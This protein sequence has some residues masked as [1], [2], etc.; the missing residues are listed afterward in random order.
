MSVK[1]NNL[2]IENVKRVKAVQL[3]PTKDGLTIIGGKNNQGKTSVLDAIAWALGGEKFKPSQAERA[4]SI[5]PP[6]LRITLSN[7][8]IVER[9][10]KN[11][12]LKVTDPS[13]QK[14]G[15]KLLDAFVEKLAL[16]LPKFMEASNKEKANILLQV[17]GV[18]DQLGVI[19]TKEKELYQERTAIGRIADQKKKY[20]DEQPYYPDVP[21]EPVSAA[22][23][24][25]EQQDI[26]ARNGE[27]H[28]KRELANELERRVERIE[29]ELSETYGKAAEIE[30][31]L[32]LLKEEYNKAVED[33]EIAFKT[34]SELEDESTAK[35]EESIANIDEINR[36]VRANLDKEKAQA[37]ADMYCR[38][39]DEL[40]A[41]LNETRKEKLDLLRS[42]DLPLSGL[43]VVEG[44]LV[45]QGQRWDNMSGSEQLRV[46]TA[47]IRKLNPECGFVLIDKLEQMDLDT[48][49]DFAN[50][51]EAERLQAI[52]TRVSTGDECSII[53]E[54][55]YAAQAETKQPAPEALKDWR[56]F[57]V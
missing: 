7:G 48:L 12:I 29:R 39:Y 25:K 28:R 8:L 47:I 49:N 13:G 40:T 51:L 37:D 54:D 10:G 21:D 3:K 11:S 5:T 44:E 36:K 6:K 32:E 57:A 14:G 30:K 42:A 18:G 31:K 17:I 2:E 4:G 19:E 22:D 34:A 53:I 15:Q 26:L 41:R 33:K 38:Q 43:T 50:W 52:A 46:A 23:L 45:Y 27:N 16:D 9:T 1:I 20:A 56:S 24:I 55:G 35:L